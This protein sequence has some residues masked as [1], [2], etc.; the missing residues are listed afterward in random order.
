MKLGLESANQ[1]TLDKLDK[2]TKVNDIINGCKIARSA[3]L[4]VHLTIMV[5]YPWETRNDAMRTLKLAKKLMREGYAE[6]LQST[7]VIPYPG[8]PLHSQAIKN[9]W[10]RIDPV[11]YERY[12]MTEPIL[13]T[14]DMSTEQIMQ[15]CDDI[16]KIFLTPKYVL[17]KIST[18]RSR[19]DIKYIL[20]GFKAVIGHIRDF[21]KMRV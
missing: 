19:E 11:D 8:T 18:I 21:A 10:F 9:N 3:G 2:G 5:G 20:R 1:K 7:I 12:D 17:R 13:K 15:I 6:M 4:E 16:Y 14:P